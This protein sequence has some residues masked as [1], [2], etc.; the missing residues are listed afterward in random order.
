M[1]P[2]KRNKYGTY[3]PICEEYELALDTMDD[4][5]WVDFEDKKQQQSGFAG[6]KERIV[7]AVTA[8]KN[9]AMNALGLKDGFSVKSCIS[10]LSGMLSAFIHRAKETIK[11]WTPAL[12]SFIDKV[13]DFI[14]SAIDYIKDQLS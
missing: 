1:V 12:K 6:L 11:N 3:L 8:L 9:K 14:Q 10:K 4:I 2:F 5:Q 7:N 13:C